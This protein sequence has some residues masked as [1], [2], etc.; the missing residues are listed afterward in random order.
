[1]NEKLL[2]Y[3][4]RDDIYYFNTGAARKAWLSFGCHYIA[5]LKM[6][7]FMVWAPNA[8][9]VTLVGDFNRWDRDATPMEPVEGG[10]WVVFVPGLEHGALYKYCVDGADGRQV[11][12]PDR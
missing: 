1:M 3:I 12:E 2:K 11:L 10:V 9:R 8:K 4:P 6:Y 7:R 5:G